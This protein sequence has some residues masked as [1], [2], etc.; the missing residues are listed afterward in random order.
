MCGDVGVLRDCGQ[1]GRLHAAR[2]LHAH[3]L[4]G[5]AD[6]RRL[7]V[8]HSAD[9][10][11]RAL[12]DGGGE[13]GGRRVRRLRP[14]LTVRRR[15]LRSLAGER[16]R[17]SLL[18][19][20]AAVARTKIVVTSADSNA[21]AIFVASKCT[22]ACDSLI[23]LRDFRAP[24]AAFGFNFLVRQGAQERRRRRRRL[25]VHGALAHYDDDD[26]NDDV[27]VTLLVACLSIVAPHRAA[28]A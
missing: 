1:I 9:K 3:F 27:G 19:H 4:H 8:A 13:N 20:S 10:R 11:R 22:Y 12:D 26:D 25:T 18:R 7:A 14:L 2:R 24:V 17:K 21:A 28:A 16:R 5:I 6:I 23:V 15:E